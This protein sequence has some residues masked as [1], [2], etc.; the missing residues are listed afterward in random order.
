MEVKHCVYIGVYALWGDGWVRGFIRFS[1][2]RADLQLHAHYC[3]GQL[4]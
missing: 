2:L 1:T 3:H 4:S